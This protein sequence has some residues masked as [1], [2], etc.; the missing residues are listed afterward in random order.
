MIMKSKAAATEIGLIDKSVSKD[1]QQSRLSAK[2]CDCDYQVACS[3]EE[4]HAAFRLI[5]DEYLRQGLTS[6]NPMRLR[7]LPHQ[8]LPTS[9]VITATLS[10]RTV[11]TLSLL[12]DGRLGLPMD[13]LYASEMDRLRDQGKRVAELTCLAHRPHVDETMWN[14]GKVRATMGTL[15][16]HVTHFAVQRGID[17]LVICVHP[18]HAK[19]YKR[20]YGFVEMGPDRCCPWATNHPAS[21]LWLDQCG[22]DAALKNFDKNG[23]NPQ[24]GELQA[25]DHGP[26]SPAVTGPFWS[27]LEEAS[28]IPS[29][30]NNVMTA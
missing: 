15:M 20:R 11:A 24:P 22:I 16:R 28:P 10:Q 23:G 19:L 9:W 8:L 29:W 30:K 26:V 25:A 14:R 17:D 1:W 27:M 2:R 3:R 12:E 13:D 21:P 18:R 4:Y 7:I 5:Y 6:R